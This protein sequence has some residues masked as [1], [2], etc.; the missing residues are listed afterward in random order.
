VRIE[1]KS[2]NSALSEKKEIILL[3]K[4]DLV[5]PKSLQSKQDELR[6]LNRDVLTVSIYDLDSIMQLQDFLRQL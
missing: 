2:F 3:T 4:S 5:E 1:L 6:R